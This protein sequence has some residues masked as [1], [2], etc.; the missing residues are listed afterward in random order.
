M[1]HAPIVEKDRVERLGE[2]ELA[3]RPS[4]GIEDLSDAA[5]YIA[6]IHQQD[7]DPIDAIPVGTFGCRQARPAADGFDSE[8]MH[9]RMP[10]RPVCAGGRRRIEDRR[11]DPKNASGEPVGGHAVRHWRE[12]ALNPAVERIVVPTL[13][14]RLMGLARDGPLEAA[15]AAKCLRR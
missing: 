4:L 14:V 8:L 1:T 15:N 2:R 6:T 3:K 7:A 10:W 12:P 13:I 11:A 9:L 5:R